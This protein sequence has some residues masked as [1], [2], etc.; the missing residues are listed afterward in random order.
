MAATVPLAH[1]VEGPASGQ[2]AVLLHGFP[3]NGSMWTAQSRHLAEGGF[4]VV[5]PDLRGHGRSPVGTGPATM[6][7]CAR[8]V[9]QLAD[10]VGAGRF[11]LGGF[12]MGG[13]VAFEICRLAPERLRGLLL[14][15]TRAE[16]DTEE[17]RAARKELVQKLRQKG[18]VAL[19]EAMGPRLV[20]ELT[21]RARQGVWEMVQS[22]IHSTPVE[23]AIASLQGMMVRRDQRPLLA[24][25]RVPTLIV[26]GAEDR[27][28]P[29]SDAVAM[30][31]GIPGAQLRIVTGAAHMTPMEAP[32]AFN[33]FLDDWL[34]GF[35]SAPARF[36]GQTRPT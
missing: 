11:W 16:P 33:H 6:E 20:S 36:L 23:G 28:T 30:Q 25:I 4:R 32:E 24:K 15:D 26:V 8:D 7:A 21:R 17:G 27:I 19:E 31:R 5:V 35:P 3:L 34:K 12:S 10:A 9:L 1:S 29:P 14:S 13:Y 2:T 22:M 18:T